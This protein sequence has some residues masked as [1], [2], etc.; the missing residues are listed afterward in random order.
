MAMS[1]EEKR[2]SNR[3][4]VARYDA[5]NDRINCRFPAGT[6]DRIKRLGYASANSFILQA[7]FDRLEREEKR[8]AGGGSD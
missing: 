8:A 2:K 5:K 4:A 3:A 6:V 1:E 7:V